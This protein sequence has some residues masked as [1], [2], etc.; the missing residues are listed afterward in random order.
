MHGRHLFCQPDT[1]LKKNPTCFL[2]ISS[3]LSHKPNIVV[4]HYKIVEWH[5]VCKMESVMSRFTFIQLTHYYLCNTHEHHILIGGF[6][7]G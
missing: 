4:P 6:L 3:F 7:N 5:K 2:H 1:H